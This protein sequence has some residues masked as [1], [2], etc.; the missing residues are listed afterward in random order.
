MKRS[1]SCDLRKNTTEERGRKRFHSCGRRQRPVLERTK[2]RVLQIQTWLGEYV[3][4]VRMLILL[5]F[6]TVMFQKGGHLDYCSGAT[7]CLLMWDPAVLAEL[8]PRWR[9]SKPLWASLRW[10]TLR[11]GATEPTFHKATVW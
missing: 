10:R 7:W 4:F 8:V 9:A 3:Q 11:E 5:I 6:R 1:L 2:H